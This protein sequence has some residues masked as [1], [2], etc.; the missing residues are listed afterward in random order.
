MLLG[1]GLELAGSRLGDPEPQAPRLRRVA[2][3]VLRGDRQLVAAPLQ[4][5]FADP[6]RELD[7]VL[8]GLAGAGEGA[9]PLQPGTAALAAVLAGGLGAHPPL[10]RLDPAALEPAVDAEA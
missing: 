4:G 6:P 5:L 1:R 10:A 2:R 3:G 8:A 7:A 9:R